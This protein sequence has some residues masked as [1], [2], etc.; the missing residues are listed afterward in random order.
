MGE[1]G[2]A[3]HVL[4]KALA[5]GETFRAIYR[6]L[7]LNMRSHHASFPGAEGYGLEAWLAVMEQRFARGGL[8]IASHLTEVFDEYVGYHRINNLVH[9]VDGDL[10][11][12]IRVG[13]M[14]LKATRRGRVRAGRVV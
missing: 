5:T 11:S 9:K 6:R 14:D 8:L 13:I 10:L 7:G 12:A 1:R 2:R 3:S 4:P